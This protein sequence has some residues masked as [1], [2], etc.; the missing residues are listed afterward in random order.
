MSYN[1]HTPPGYPADSGAWAYDAQQD[2]QNLGYA[3]SPG[4]GFLDDGTWVSV[5]ADPA[6]PAYMQG[7]V[8]MPYTCYVPGPDNGFADG[9]QVAYGAYDSI[10]HTVQNAIT[11]PQIDPLP[12]IQAIQVPAA[13]AAS[14]NIPAPD[15]PSEADRHAWLDRMGKSSDTKQIVKHLTS[16]KADM[17]LIL[18]PESIS[19]TGIAPLWYDGQQIVM[20]KANQVPFVVPTF[21]QKYLDEHLQARGNHIGP[22][23]YPCKSLGMERHSAG[24]A[25]QR[26]SDDTVKSHFYRALKQF[27]GLVFLRRIQKDL[28]GSWSVTEKFYVAAMVRMLQTLMEHGA[29]R[30]DAIANLQTLSFEHVTDMRTYVNMTFVINGIL[31]T[32]PDACINL[33]EA[34]KSSDFAHDISLRR[35]FL[36]QSILLFQENLIRQHSVQQNW[37]KRGQRRNKG[38]AE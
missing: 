19:W 33:L 13:P 26:I 10:P 7:M 30:D 36:N 8:A 31:V 20:S 18:C 21:A 4:Y 1:Y 34:P 29:S 35:T 32:F 28:C 15:M 17:A 2:E 12:D 37:N 11:W 3:M 25:D 16:Y 22:L 5:A 27:P 6:V 24:S 9:A 14:S 38:A 23:F